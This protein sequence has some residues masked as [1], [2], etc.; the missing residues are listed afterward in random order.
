MYACTQKWYSVVVHPENGHLLV[1]HLASD[2][3]HSQLPEA[4]IREILDLDRDLQPFYT[5]LADE[6]VAR[7]ALEQHKGLRLIRIPDLFEALSWTIIGQQINLRFA[8]TLKAR[9]VG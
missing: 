3:A 1:R 8:Y 2:T 5:H 7:H 6:P 9:L 4:E